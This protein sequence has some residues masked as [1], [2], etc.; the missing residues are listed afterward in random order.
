M[1]PHQGVDVQALDAYAAAGEGAV[2]VRA[3]VDE[4]VTVEWSAAEVAA[5]VAGLHGHRAEHP[6]P[7]P[8]DLAFRED[9]EEDHQLFLSGDPGVDVAAE[10]RYPYF[11]A[12]VLEERG[13]GGEL[14]AVEGTFAGTDDDRVEVPVRIG[15][16]GEQCGRLR[17]VC[18]GHC[19]AAADVEELGHDPSVPG[20]QCLGA[21]QLPGL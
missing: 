12:V 7:G 2:G 1:G 11:D 14:V 8:G 18:P 16:R 15:H 20:C 6:D 13:H 10:F 5:L 3:G 19:A 17:S 9:T 21:Q 4:A